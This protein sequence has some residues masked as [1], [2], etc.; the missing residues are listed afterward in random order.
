MMKG[1]F[2]RGSITFYVI[3]NSFLQ[4]FRSSVNTGRQL[5]VFDCLIKLVNADTET[6]FVD[7]VSTSQY[8]ALKCVHS[9]HQ[10]G[11]KFS[12]AKFQ[13]Y[14]KMKILKK[15]WLTNANQPKAL[16]VIISIC[17]GYEIYEPTIWS[18][19]LKKMVNL[20]MTKELR[21][22]IDTISAKHS[23]VHLDGLV[24][25]WEYLIRMPFKNISK[26]RSDEQDANICNALFLLQSCP[27]KSRMK[28]IELVELCIQFRQLNIAAVFIA[29]V[30]NE[31]RSKVVEMIKGYRSDSLKN[32]IINLREFGIYPFVVDIAIR[33]LGL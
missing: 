25:A 20:H 4:F 14:D 3:F 24:V 7:L 21:T 13:S 19:V 33:E 9:L 17:V 22:I 2:L 1:W 11:F 30:G 27:V 18:N 12:V 16:D 8:I 15:L 31:H 28:L 5:Q 6:P 29:F 23:L 26:V 32:D 10:F